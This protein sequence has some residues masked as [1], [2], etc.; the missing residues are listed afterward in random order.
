M[1]TRGICEKSSRGTQIAD[2]GAYPA[3]LRSR[4]KAAFFNGLVC[5][6]IH[7]SGRHW[8]SFFMLL[9]CEKFHK[10]RPM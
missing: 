4:V 2:I 8:P 6:I 10:V 7:R 3:E 9:I 5:E 1:N